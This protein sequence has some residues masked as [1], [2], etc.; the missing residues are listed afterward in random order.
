MLVDILPIHI[1]FF[2]N[3]NIGF[4]LI[5]GIGDDIIACQVENRLLV[6][7]TELVLAQIVLER[8]ISEYSVIQNFLIEIGGIIDH[9]IIFLL[10]N[11]M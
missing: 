7:S 1:Q 5:E 8:A 9:L 2:Q 4:I 6:A 10:R 11:G 3:G